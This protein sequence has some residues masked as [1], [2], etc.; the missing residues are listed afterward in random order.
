MVNWEKR[1]EV[2]IPEIQGTGVLS[3]IPPGGKGGLLGMIDNI[4]DR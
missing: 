1:G 3:T 2:E 4:Y